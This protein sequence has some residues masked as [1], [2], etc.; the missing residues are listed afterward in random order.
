MVN[1][2]DHPSP[3]VV[4]LH[5]L[6]QTSLV[7]LAGPRIS[8]VP[9]PHGDDAIILVF[10]MRD[11]DQAIAPQLGRELGGPLKQLRPSGHDA[12]KHFEP[13]DGPSRH[14]E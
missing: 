9:V 7:A 8:V 4:A 2:V 3:A 5:P 6:R 1:A 14:S 13:H 11:G 12:A 10:G